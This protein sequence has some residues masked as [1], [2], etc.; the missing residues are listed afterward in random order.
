MSEQRW[1]KHGDTV[2]FYRWW[3]VDAWWTPIDI[4]IKIGPLAVFTYRWDG[5]RRLS[6]TWLC[7]DEHIVMN[8]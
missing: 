7:W 3:T 4:G 6:W 1:F 8:R 5:H 2:G